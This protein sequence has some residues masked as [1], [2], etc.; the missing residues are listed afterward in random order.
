M[1]KKALVLLSALCL[2]ATVGCNNNN[3]STSTNN[4]TSSQQPAAKKYSVGLGYNG[5]FEY[6]ADDATTEKNEELGQLDLTTAFAAFDEDGKIFDVRLDVVQVKF[7]ANEEKTGLT[8]TNTN[9]DSDNSVTTKLELGSAYGMVAWGGAVAEVNAQIE[10]FAD[11][12][13]GK[14][15]AEV[16]NAIPAGAG[17][18]TAVHEELTGSVTISVDAF[19]S[20]LEVAYENKT[21]ATYE[22]SSTATAGVAMQSGLA[23]NYG[24]PTTEVSVDVA[25]VMVNNGTVEAAQIDAIVFPV[26]IADDR[27]LTANAE[28]KYIGD[29]GE[30]LSKKV[31]G[32]A[33]AMAERNEGMP[34]CTKEWYE[35]A[36][37]I[38]TAAQGKTKDQISALVANEGDLA[39]ATITLTSYLKA[40]AKATDYAGRTVIN[41][42]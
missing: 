25:G 32:D 34:G 39:G 41:A 24:N 30:L 10:S 27:T 15:V 23:Y 35:Q 20:A 37:V 36:A 3:S 38:E 12:T 21:D 11:W 13:K 5:S 28:E 18:G 8:L 40:L 22:L 17:H 42:N 6:T 9:L 29:N 26:A 7:V 31:L 1:N 19:I 2:G 4:N 33:Y 16:R 14:T